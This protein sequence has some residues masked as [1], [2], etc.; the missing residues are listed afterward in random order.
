M[1]PVAVSTLVLPQAPSKTV[2]GRATKP[3]PVERD[4]S[5]YVAPYWAL[6]AAISAQFVLQWVFQQVGVKIVW[7]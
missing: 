5:G 2:K 3:V 6:T 1:Y 7:K 4:D